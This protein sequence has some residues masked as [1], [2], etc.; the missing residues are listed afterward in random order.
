MSDSLIVIPVTEATS[1][2]A[3]MGK[4]R[5]KNKFAAITMYF[6]YHRK[7]ESDILPPC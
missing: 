3:I 1:F 4:E 2:M 5:N 7:N 6:D